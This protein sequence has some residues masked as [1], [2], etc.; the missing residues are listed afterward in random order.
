[1]EDKKAE[2]F[3]CAKELFSTKGFKATNVS[4]ITKMAG[5]GV[6]TF[7]NY[8]SSKEQ[9]FIEIFMKENDKL[10]ES[11]KTVDVDSDPVQAVKEILEI[12]FNGIN[13]NPILKEWYN[14]DLFGK[15]EKE[16]NKRGGIKSIAETMNSDTLELIKKWKNDGK[17]RNDL[18]DD[19]ILAI[20]NAIPYIDI[21][22]KEIGLQYFP[23]ILLYISE[24]VMRGLT[25]C[26]K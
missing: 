14:R 2:I 15:L 10:K 21:H 24:F 9:L 17:I 26:R 23:Q 16:F 12:N 7:Y 19:L 18:D 11:F 22:K 20:F 1:M 6:G 8:Y 3:N 4:D 13:T 5:I 25:D